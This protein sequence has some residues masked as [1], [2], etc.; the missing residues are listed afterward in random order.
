VA[1]EWLSRLVF[2]RFHRNLLADELIMHARIALLA[3]CLSWLAYESH[4]SP[5]FFVATVEASVA[6]ILGNIDHAIAA[7]HTVLVKTAAQ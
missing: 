1:A 6:D 4:F 7:D 3:V 2:T 5:K